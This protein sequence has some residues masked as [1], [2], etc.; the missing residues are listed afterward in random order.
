VGL[1]D[2][3]E[4][5]IDWRDAA[6][7]FEI[8]SIILVWSNWVW[9]L[10][11]TRRLKKSNRQ[12]IT[13]EKA[14]ALTTKMRPETTITLNKASFRADEAITGTYHHSSQLIVFRL[15][16]H[17]LEFRDSRGQRW[18]VMGCESGVARLCTNGYTVA[19]PSAKPWTPWETELWN[20]SCTFP[21]LR[22]YPVSCTNLGV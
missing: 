4:L 16:W 20:C 21:F 11:M 14:V 12:A 22:L 3:P 18:E 13:N 8:N 9:H 1:L 15:R 5:L 7:L 10:Q 17:W 6:V 19:W 2:G